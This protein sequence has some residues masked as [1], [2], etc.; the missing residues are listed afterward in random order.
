MLDLNEIVEPSSLRRLEPSC[1]RGCC[2]YLVVLEPAFVFPTPTDTYNVLQYLKPESQISE[3]VMAEQNMARSLPMD[4][5]NIVKFFYAGIGVAENEM[6]SFILSEFCPDKVWN[7][8]VCLLAY[9]VIWLS[10]AKEA[11]AGRY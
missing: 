8:G 2:G 9:E 6:V 5:A 7:M 11:D 10:M 4:H 3:W 1:R